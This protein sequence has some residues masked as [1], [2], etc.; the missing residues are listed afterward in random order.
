MIRLVL[1]GTGNVSKAIARAVQKN[2]KINLIHVI[3]R[4]NQ[5]S[6]TYPVKVSYTT[7]PSKLPDCDLILLTVQDQMIKSASDKL[8]SH[9]AVVAHTSG[10]SNIDI[11]SAH[12][13]RGVLYP[14]QTFSDKSRLEWKN[15]PICWEANT[16]K[17]QNISV[18]MFC[19][20]KP[21]P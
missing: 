8:V 3:G 10:A 7:D 5:L 6:T 12:K 1:V 13:H 11:L 20:L 2:N 21:I 18:R 19:V 17:T 14:I 9:H 15:I 16:L 4:D